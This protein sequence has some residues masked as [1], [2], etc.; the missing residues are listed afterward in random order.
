MSY[1][2]FLI[3]MA[4]KSTNPILYTIVYVA[5]CI[6]PG[7]GAWIRTERCS[8]RCRVIRLSHEKWPHQHIDN[9]T[10]PAQLEIP[11][12]CRDFSIY[13]RRVSSRYRIDC[14][15]EADKNFLGREGICLFAPFWSSLLCK[16]SRFTF[17]RAWEVTCI[18][19]TARQHPSHSR[20]RLPTEDAWLKRDWTA[21]L[22]GDSMEIHYD[23]CDLAMCWLIITLPWKYRLA[24][25]NFMAVKSCPNFGLQSIASLHR[26]CI[27]Y[28]TFR[29]IYV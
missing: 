16:I 15:L 8:S 2:V 5:T 29:S 21:A 6:N 26:P 17:T 25:H 11:G 4:W 9:K 13:I 3:G 27:M 7:T 1:S 12:T 19:I 18:A 10:R 14:K 24:I 22:H 23:Y 28:I 20:S